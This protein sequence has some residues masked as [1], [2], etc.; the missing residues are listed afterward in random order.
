MQKLIIKILLCFYLFDSFD[1][2]ANNIVI[3]KI[4]I[5]DN[6]NGFQNQNENPY[7]YIKQNDAKLNLNFNQ[8]SI[9]VFFKADSTKKYQFHLSNFSNEWF[10][11]SDNH[12][13][14]TSLPSEEYLLSIREKRGEDISHLKIIIESPIWL[15]WWFLPM[16]FFY[17]LIIVGVFLYFLFQYRLRQQTRT[18]HIRDN[19]ARDLHDDMGSYLS[20]ISIL[21]QNVEKL[22]LTDPEKAKTSLQ[23]IGETARQVMDTMDDIVWSIN[24]MHDSMEQIMNRMKDFGNEIFFSQEVEMEFLASDSVKKINISLEKRRDFF[25]VFREALTNIQ[26]YAQ[27]SKVSV[28]LLRNGNQIT[29][30]INDNGCGFDI[31]NLPKSR[32][33]GGNGLK[34]MQARAEKLGGKLQIESKINIGTSIKLEFEQ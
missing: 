2:E 19:I 6:R 13:L 17:A 15:R 29:M 7:I 22:T 12:F 4:K 28:Q 33:M 16:M 9:I 25:L 20:S 30:L 14:L 24:P 8:N 10:D 31:D 26:K 11:I 18:Q 1:C 32:T 27:A 34:N 5:L 21:S 3:S 23:K